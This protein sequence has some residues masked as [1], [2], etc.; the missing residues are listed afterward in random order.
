MTTQL[1]HHDCRYIL[2]DYLQ[3]AGGAE[4]LSLTLTSGFPEYHLVVSRVFPEAAVLTTI[5][6]LPVLCIGNS[7][8]AMLGR[9]PEAI[10]CFRHS[11]NFLRNAEVVLYSGFYAPLAVENQRSGRKVYYCHT[12]P[13]YLYDL[14]ESYK[15]CVSPLLLPVFDTGLNWLRSEYERALWQMDRV[16][17]NSVNV[18]KRLKK[19]I[20]IESE[21]IFPPVDVDRFRWLGEGEYFIS[22]ARLSRSKRVDVIIRAFLQMPDKKLVVLSGGQE[23]DALRKLAGDAKNIHFTGWQSEA[24]IQQWIGN[25]CAAIYLP[26]DEDFG[27]SPVEA[28]AAGKPVIGVAEGGLLETIVNGETGWLLESP[29]SVDMLI[30]TVRQLDRDT[31]LAMRH[32]CEA[33]AKLFS[34]EIFLEKMKAVL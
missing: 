8:T 17:A 20:G 23:M 11:A 22:L 29:P 3:F 31:V 15:Q 1:C 25:A 21:V 32:A 5:N 6:S 30:D 2:Y 18:Q 26:I 27:M 16:I 34:R 13:R 28:M 14:S 33:R 24:E 9:I 7:I 10:W 4:R 19:F 12:P